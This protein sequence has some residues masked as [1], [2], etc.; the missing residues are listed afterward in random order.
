MSIKNFYS[1]LSKGF[2]SPLYLI[3]SSDDFLL[4]EC[5]SLIQKNQRRT[6][7][8]NFSLYDLDSLEQCPSVK[9]II[10]ELNTFPF[11][12]EKKTVILKNLQK[13][14]KKDIN[15]LAD[16]L[17]NPSEFTIFIML[18]T[19]DYKKI[20]STETLKKTKIINISIANLPVWLNEKAKNRGVQLTPNAVKYLIGMTGEDLTTLNSE[21]EKLSL[22]GS[23]VIDTDDLKEIVYDGSKFSAFDLA[24][25][26]QRGD[27]KSAF[28]IYFSLEKNT[29]PL[30]LLGALNWHYRSQYNKSAEKEKTKYHYIFKLIFKTDILLK[31]SS[32]TAIEDLIMKI[33]QFEG[34]AQK[35][36]T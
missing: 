32:K 19:G 22:F 3:S 26:L 13:T 1:E 30:V 4:S 36:G 23:K 11:F 34:K 17:L 24:N 12:G 14:P 33:L 25:A 6:D 15:K 31:S 7:P 21:I 29:D 10:A 2:P 28:R 18:C 16:Y 9:E 35:Q 5:L 20:F 27:K 8:L